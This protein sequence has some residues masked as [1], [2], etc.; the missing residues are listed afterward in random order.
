MTEKLQIVNRKKRRGQP[1]PLLIKGMIGSINLKDEAGK[2]C[3]C[4]RRFVQHKFLESE[5]CS[6]VASQN[7]E[8]KDNAINHAGLKKEVIV[9][10]WLHKKG[11]GQDMLGTTSWKPRW[12]ELVLSEIVGFDVTVPVLLIYWLP[13]MPLPS[14]SIVLD[15]VVVMPIDQKVSSWDAYCFDIVPEKNEHQMSDEGMPVT[16]SFTAPLLQRNQ[17][18]FSLNHT[19]N[20][21]EKRKAKFRS[22]KAYQEGLRTRMSQLPP[23]PWKYKKPI[24]PVDSTKRG[25]LSPAIERRIYPNDARPQNRKFMTTTFPPKMK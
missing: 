25:I 21:Y 14:S 22:N 7:L 19:L 10:G 8:V 18:V 4:C 1:S 15:Q 23:S 24:V 13:S 12:A 6:P 9:K 20:E 2:A 17:W 3:P 11:S 5:Y 16:R